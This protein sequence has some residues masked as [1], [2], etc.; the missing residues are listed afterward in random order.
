MGPWRREGLLLPGV[1]GTER[2][3]LTEEEKWGLRG[4]KQG[5]A[6]MIKAI[7]AEETACDQHCTVRAQGWRAPGQGATEHDCFDSHS[8][9]SPAPSAW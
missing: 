2:R 8:P 5:L 4:E 7:R 6:P 3:E 1:A 9:E